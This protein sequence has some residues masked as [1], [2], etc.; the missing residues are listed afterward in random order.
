MFMRRC[1]IG[2]KVVAWVVWI[3]P[4]GSAQNLGCWCRFLRVN[5]RLSERFCGELELLARIRCKLKGQ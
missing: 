2:V 5:L 4:M 3:W 1:E